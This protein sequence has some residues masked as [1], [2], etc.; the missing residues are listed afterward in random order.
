MRPA[1]GIAQLLY[2]ALSPLAL[3]API[4]TPFVVEE[5]FEGLQPSDTI[6]FNTR[7]TRLQVTAPTTFDSG[8]I[9]A[10][11]I[12]EGLVTIEDCTMSCGFGLGVAHGDIPSDGDIPDGHAYFAVSKLREP[13]AFEFILPNLSRTVSAAVS[14]PEGRTLTLTAFDNQGEVIASSSI[15]SV[16]ANQWIENRISVTASGIQKVSFELDT[17]TVFVID[18]LV[19]I[20]V[21]EPS[22]IALLLACRLGVLVACKL[23]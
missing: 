13:T 4:E 15:G 3:S 18:Q 5:S 16:P 9:F 2:F 11:P 10:G 8:V 19:A 7:I 22:A 1:H 17:D 12:T 20:S 6:I 14:A 21:P 23:A